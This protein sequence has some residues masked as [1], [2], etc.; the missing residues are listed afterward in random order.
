MIPD[1]LL[2]APHFEADALLAEA[3]ALPAEAWFPHFNKAYYEGDW[4][5]LA[6]RSPGG[7]V[8]IPDAAKKEPYADTIYLERCPGVR[9]ALARL[10]TTVSWVR[11]LRLGPGARI[12]EHRDYRIGLEF[13]EVRI[14]IPLETNAD[15]NFE[16]AGRAWPMRAG[17]CWYVDVTEPH[18]VR[19]DGS[20]PRIHIVADCEVNAWLR[21]ELEEAARLAF[22]RFA[23]RVATDEALQRELWA[24][25]DHAAFAAR[26]VEAGARHGFAFA[27]A[28]V[29]SAIRATWDRQFDGI[30]R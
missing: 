23:A 12:L 11:F 8:S 7:C 27:E 17:E 26:A 1:R 19:N 21:R 6:L 5:A 25:E 13:G 16:L 3:L 15:V 29:A 9:Q 30:N 10:E 22:P 20:A 18:S 14:H 4:S 2:L 28:E 24:V